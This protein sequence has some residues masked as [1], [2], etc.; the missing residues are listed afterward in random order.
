MLNNL[1]KVLFNLNSLSNRQNSTLKTTSKRNG[2]G[3]SEA[4]ETLAKKKKRARKEQ[5]IVDPLVNFVKKPNHCASDCWH[6]GKISM[7]LL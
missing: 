6:R 3:G 4:M 5:I 7:L 1:L 2:V